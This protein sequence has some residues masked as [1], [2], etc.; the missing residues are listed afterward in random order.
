M[1]DRTA[2]HASP[3]TRAEGVPTTLAVAFT[4]DDLLDLTALVAR[5][6]RDGADRDWSAPAGSLDWSCTDTAV[7]VVDTVLAPAFF[8]ASRKQDDY[9][10]FGV[11]SPAP[12]L[13]RRSSSRRWRRRPGSRRPS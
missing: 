2:R 11:F 4:C 12:T 5:A 10:G 6:W 8:L 13:G 3:R 1:A 9:P 7:H